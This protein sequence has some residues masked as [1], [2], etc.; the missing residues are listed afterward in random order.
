MK[1]FLLLVHLLCMITLILPTTVS[2]KEIDQ[3]NTIAITAKSEHINIF[4]AKTQY[5]L[6]D[7]TILET[8]AD[9]FTQNP[10]LSFVI[11]NDF[12]WASDHYLPFIQ[13]IS[14]SFSKD[15]LD[16][17]YKTENGKLLVYI[18]NSDSS[19][20]E[21]F[22]LSDLVIEKTTVGGI[23]GT[24]ALFVSTESHPE[25]MILIPNMI[26]LSEYIPPAETEPLSIVIPL[27]QNR[28]LIN[29]TER[30]LREPAYLSTNGYAMLPLR[31]F[32]SIFTKIQLT[33]DAE[34]QV[35][36]AY[37]AGIFGTM[38]VG[39]TIMKTNDI[40]ISQNQEIPLCNA[41]EMKNGRTFLSL[42]DIC[43]FYHVPDED[44]HWNADT[45]TI[46]IQTKIPV[47]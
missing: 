40:Y 39:D 36:R 45:K 37:Y 23:L 29:D 25:N 31:D 24:Y 2:A 12:E 4:S 27:D 9:A 28:M 17:E 13:G 1:K 35:V 21:S 3:N 44:I 8:S 34:Q 10:T 22:S 16:V 46:T 42:R 38:S 18:K 5:P 32:S 20:Q 19:K 30:I 15:T 33:W 43:H 11:K 41:V 47:S 14:G 7:I 6:K 26:E